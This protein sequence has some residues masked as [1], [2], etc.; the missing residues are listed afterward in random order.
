V[1][2]ERYAAV[3]LRAEALRVARAPVGTRND[4]LNRA[5]F[6]LG[7]LVAAGLLDAGTVTHELSAAARWSGL[8]RAE[9]ARTVRSGLRAGRR[10]PM[11]VRRRRAA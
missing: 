1:H 11:P 7:R 8:D 2:P 4:T 6:A 10:Q 3:A 5:A 9:T